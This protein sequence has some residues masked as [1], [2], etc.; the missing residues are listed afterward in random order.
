MR[1]WSGW[2]LRVSLRKL[3]WLGG[4]ALVAAPALATAPALGEAVLKGYLSEEVGAVMDVGPPPDPASEAGRRDRD[5]VLK[6]RPEVGS[7][8]W[9]LAQYDADLDPDHGARFFDCVLGMRVGSRQPEALSRLFRR[10]QADAQ[11]AYEPARARYGRPRPAAALDIPLCLARD[12]RF[13]ASPSYPS[14][15]MATAWAWTLA[16]ADM[17]PDRAAEIRARGDALGRERVICGAHFPSDIAAGKAVGSAVYARA[18][19]APEFVADLEAAREA[20]SDLR[21]QGGQAPV[22]AAERLA[23]GGDR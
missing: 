2:A 17:A 18:A 11:K 3:A 22:C 16:M 1:G 23:L 14:G 9:T 10:L 21:R 15:Y 8:I 4:A 13:L 12:P 7:P 20:L 5:L 19:D 6:D